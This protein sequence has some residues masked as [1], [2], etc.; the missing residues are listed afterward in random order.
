MLKTP[1]GWLLLA[2]VVILAVIVVV[3][4]GWEALIIA[5]IVIGLCMA[6]YYVYLAVTTVTTP[7]LT[8]YERGKLFDK[9]LFNVVLGFAG[10][11]A[12]R[13]GPDG[14]TRADAPRRRCA[15]LATP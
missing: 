3:L 8:P 6:A 14:C 4:F 13:S 2:I 1:L 7:G 15:A 5:G 11:E 10:V 12:H 9:A